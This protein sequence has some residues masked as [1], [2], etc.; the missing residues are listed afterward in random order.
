MSFTDLFIKKPVLSSVISLL[1]LALGLYSLNLLPILQYPFTENAIVT[2]STAY[3]GADPELVAG[4]IT[5][6]LEN[7]IA[8]ADG[9][10]YMTSSSTE[11]FSTITINLLLNYDPI[12]ALADINAK[13]S[14]VINQLPKSS[15]LPVM[16]VSVGQ[17][18]DSMYIGFYSKQ[19]NSS[20]ITDYLIR[21]VQPKLQ[22]VN[23]VQL[24]EILGGQPFAMRAWL[25]PIKL[26]GFNLTPNDVADALAR[27]DFISAVGRTDG[28]MLTLNLTAL[29]G[30]HSVE[31]F[32]NLILGSKNGAIIRLRDVAQV[33]LGAENYNS[34]VQF[35]GT[36]AVYIGIKVAPSANLLSVID[37]VKALLPD[38]QSQLPNGISSKIVYDATAYVN[39]SIDEVIRSLLEALGIVTLVV[40]VFLGSPRS[41]IIPV[42]AIPLSL[43][44]AFFV[45]YL[46]GY[47]INLLTLLALVLAIGLVVDDAIII[48][49]N[50]NRH[51]EMGSSP[52]QAAI[53]GTRELG[54]PNY[55]NDCNL[56]RCLRS[57]WI[58]GRFNRCSIF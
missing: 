25:D 33:T 45:M 39:D 26:A 35:D 58:Y 37:D 51:M 55:C 1:I 15:Q 10:D 2:V 23:G 16:S 32:K 14:A 19:L 29:T 46:L 38:I 5:T 44:G 22:A 3:V 12:R 8:Q 6:P 13:I 21:V 40:F 17:T 24:A 41:I 56:I 43:I 9:I 52:V 34:A 47:S 57:H 11:G 50:V 49:E 27:N 30:L 42:V 53:D 36:P 4:Y 31:E 18:I 54:G 20:Q 48:V 7:S 28:D